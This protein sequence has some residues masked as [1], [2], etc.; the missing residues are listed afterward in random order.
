MRSDDIVDDELGRVLST[1]TDYFAELVHDSAMH[2]HEVEAVAVC[3]HT[4]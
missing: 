1:V 3:C 2:G 4:Y